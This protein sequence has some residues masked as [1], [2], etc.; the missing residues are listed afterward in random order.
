[1]STLALD[2]AR[3]ISI[4]EITQGL[5]QAAF[6]KVK[7]LNAAFQA[8]GFASVFA[9]LNKAPAEPQSY[10]SVTGSI[11]QSPVSMSSSL[12]KSKNTK[13]GKEDHD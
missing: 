11:S 8:Q 6:A 5:G 13:K 12:S 4:L 7:E 10:A 3:P 2:S 1:M 9:S